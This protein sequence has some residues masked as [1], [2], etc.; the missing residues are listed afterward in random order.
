MLPTIH[1]VK[2]ATI[3]HGAQRRQPVCTGAG[4]LAEGVPGFLISDA[5]LLMLFSS[6]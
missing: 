2:I 3:A 5:A 6:D 1:R 4:A